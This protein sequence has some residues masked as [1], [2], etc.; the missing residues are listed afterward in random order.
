[1]RRFLHRNLG[2]VVGL[3]RDMAESAFLQKQIETDKMHQC[4]FINH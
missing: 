2:A 3:T 4:V 1:M